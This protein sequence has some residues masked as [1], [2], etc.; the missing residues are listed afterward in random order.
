M[1][2]T[3]TTLKTAIQDYLENDETTFV[4]N[5]PVIVQQAEDRILK[6]VQLPDFRRNVTG[7]LTSGSQYLGSPTDFLAPY[8]LA[9]NNSG[10]E[11]LIFKDVNFIRE[12]YPVVS[13]TGVPRYY[14]IW[15]DDFFIVGPTPNASFAVEL[16]YFYRPTSI[17]TASTSWLGDHAE[18]TLLA[19]CLLES[20]IFLKGDADMMQIYE[21]R[22]KEALGELKLLAEGRNKTDEYRAA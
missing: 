8:S 14:S 4:A 1:A 9:L 6:N 22:Y 21:A 11:F 17:V 13:T 3:Y 10:L 18:S 20:Y 15:D 12:V 19:A 7:S 16:H 5:L 2:W